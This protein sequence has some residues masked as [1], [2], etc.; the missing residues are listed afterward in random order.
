MFGKKKESHD[1]PHQDPAPASANP[2]APPARGP[3]HDDFDRGQSLDP[4]A[5]ERE[6]A[7]VRHDGLGPTTHFDNRSDYD[8]GYRE[9]TADGQYAT[10]QYAAD[11]HVT[12]QH[13]APQAPANGLVTDT[14]PSGLVT[15][16]VTGQR[17][18][19]PDDHTRAIPAVGDHRDYPDTAGDPAYASG[20][21]AYASEYDDT[22]QI[23]AVD[24][25]RDYADTHRTAAYDDDPYDDATDQRSAT[26]TGAGVAGAGVA[27]AGVAGA[28][29]G[30]AVAPDQ[31]ADSAEARIAADEREKGGYR[32]NKLGGWL[33]GILRILL[34]FQFFWAFIDK[35]FGLGYSTPNDAAWVNGG[36][37]TEGFLQGVTADD[38]NN[39]FKP[40]FQ[41]FLDQS[42]TDWVFM[43]GLV[44]I[45]IALILGIAMWFTSICAAALLVLMYLAAWPIEQNPFV[46]SHLLSAVTVL[47]LA[48]CNAGAY[49]GLGRAWKTR[50]AHR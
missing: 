12:D 18:D 43:V 29:V 48:A 3:E 19:V 11:Q 31:D 21:S 25:R 14:T 5:R 6:G 20:D 47:A 33:L 49:I 8:A 36:S 50:R 15:D 10:D 13:V 24:D 23:P 28:G 26:A 38:S 2:T 7:Q 40:M 45:G 4:V 27:G 41:F 46:D 44:G 1:S 39:P 9:P 16:P 17:T 42:W 34:G 37:P 35:T 30:T 22:R 32:I